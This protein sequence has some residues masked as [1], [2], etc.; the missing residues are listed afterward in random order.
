[1]SPSRVCMRRSRQLIIRVPPISRYHSPKGAC[2][3]QRLT[4]IL[5]EMFAPL[6]WLVWPPR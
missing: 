2:P 6:A 3:I 5:S 1:M 4:Q